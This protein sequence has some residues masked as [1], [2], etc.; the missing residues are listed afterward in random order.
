MLG[1]PASDDSVLVGL[2]EADDAAVVKLDGPDALVLTLDFFTPLVDDAFT[3]GQIA[4]AN[5]ASDVYAMGARP[6]VALNIVGWP[7]ET[8]PLDL[9]GEVLKGGLDIAQRAGFALVGGH[10]VDDPEPKY[11]MVVVGRADPERLMTLDAAK[12]GDDLVITKSIGTGVVTTALKA[13]EAPAAAVDAAVHSMTQLNDAAS[14][15]FVEAGVRACT[16]V[17]GF[18]LLGHLGRM[19]AASGVGAEIDASAVPLLPGALDLARA[20]HVPGGTRRNLD[21]ARLVDWGEAGELTRIMLC[22]A[23]TSGGLLAAGRGLVTGTPIGRV[24]E[25]ESGTI[26]VRGSVV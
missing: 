14:R 8:L 9:L 19:L 5:A 24:V 22:D 4:A 17:T 16:D 15:E 10:T 3:W 26:S 13:D 7:R 12:P 2:I 6:L 11:G 1:S 23:Q 25:G 18:G 20:G 21:A